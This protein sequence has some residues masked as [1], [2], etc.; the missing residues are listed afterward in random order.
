MR[1]LVLHIAPHLGG[2]VGRFFAN[3]LPF[4]DLHK[5]HFLLLEKPKNRD[6]LDAA[7]ISWEIWTGDL[8]ALDQKVSEAKLVEIDFW[9]HPALLA[10]LHECKLKYCNLVVYSF[11]SGTHSPNILPTELFDFADWI[12]FPGPSSLSSRELPKDKENYSVVFALGGVDRTKTLKSKIHKGINVAYIGTAGY[13]KL[14]PEFVDMCYSILENNAEVRFSLATVDSNTHIYEDVNQRKIERNFRFFQNI[15]DISTVLCTADIF[16]YPLR[17][18][19]YGTGEQAL[20]EAMGAGVPPVVLNNSAESHIVSDKETGFIADNATEYVEAILR[21][22]SDERMRK[23]LGQ[24]ARRYAI[25]NF[26]QR[27]TCRKLQETYQKITEEY[28][29]RNRSMRLVQNTVEKKLGWE[30]FLKCLGKNSAPTQWYNSLCPS[31]RKYWLEK[32]QRLEYVSAKNKG[33]LLAYLSYF[34]EDEI[35]NKYLREVASNNSAE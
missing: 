31:A 15:T 12:I 1:T 10:F 32:S 6:F 19:H 4:D 25:K 27:K 26:C 18:D 23:I 9:N 16:G 28:P 35:L 22:A 11:V 7:G 14:H 30:L 29:P 2:G 34:P 21:L 3:V 33:G 24:N 20:L 13:Q 17:H 8:Q 5:H